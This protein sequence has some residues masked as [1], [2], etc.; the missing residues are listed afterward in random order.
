LEHALDPTALLRAAARTFTPVDSSSFLVIEVP[1]LDSAE[2]FV[3]WKHRRV[4]DSFTE[5]VWHFCETALTKMVARYVPGT[6]LVHTARPVH[7]KLQMVW[8]HR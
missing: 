8:R 6:R 3:N 5:H 2:D 4:S 1:D 7:G